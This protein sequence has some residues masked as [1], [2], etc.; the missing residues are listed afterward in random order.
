MRV[1]S[2]PLPEVISD[3]VCPV[4]QEM[5][6][7]RAASVYFRRRPHRFDIDSTGG[8][9]ASLKDLVELF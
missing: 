5:R 8:L 7:S 4:C 9:S 3:F 2:E 1:R 6:G